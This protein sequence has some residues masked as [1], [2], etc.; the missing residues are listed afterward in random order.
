MLVLKKSG[1]WTSQFSKY[2]R[3]N[4]PCFV[5]VD[6]RLWI[7]IG[8]RKSRRLLS[9][10]NR[11][12]RLDILAETLIPF[13]IWK[14]NWTSKNGG[15]DPLWNETEISRIQS[16]KSQECVWK[17]CFSSCESLPSAT[18]E[19]NSE[20]QRIK[21][22]AFTLSGMKTIQVL[23]SSEVVCNQSFSECISLIDMITD[24]QVL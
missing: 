1:C 13:V 9:F 24:L 3:S 11:W 16:E 4:I 14:R 23:A 21:E 19:N 22:F 6:D 17:S 2:G 12:R 8:D 20:L 7:R 5:S 18:F 15:C 10:K